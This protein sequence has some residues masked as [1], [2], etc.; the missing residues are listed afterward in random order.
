[1]AQGKIE[2]YDVITL[3]LICTLGSENFSTFTL[4]YQMVAFI[5]YLITV[6][7]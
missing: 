3:W 6:N 1:M 7:M 2:N 5:G 4:A